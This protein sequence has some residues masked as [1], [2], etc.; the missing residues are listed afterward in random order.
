MSR[1]GGRWVL[2]GL[3]LVHLASLTAPFLAPYSPTGQNRRAPWSP[4]SRIRLVDAG[5]GLHWRPFVH[6]R[7]RLADGSWGE[8]TSRRLPLRIFVRGEPYRLFG[9]LEAD[10]HLFGVDAPDRVFLLGTDGLGRD[11]LSRL[12]FGARV[13][14]FA[15][16]AAAALALSLG[17]A[18]GALAGYFRGWADILVMRL[19]EVVLSLPA[20]YLLLGVRAFLPLEL[21]ATDSFL[22]IVA[23]IGLLGWP[24]PARLVRGV[25]LSGRERGY[26]T[27][28]RGFGASDLYLLRRHVLPQTVDVVLTQAAI[29]VPAYILAEVTLSFLGLGVSE[30]AASLGNMLAVLQRP[31]VLASY[32]WM[33][34]PAALLVVVILAYYALGEALKAESGNR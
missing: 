6:P 31:Q 23:I 27:A 3:V 29:L 25:V 30:P 10:R 2:A 19:V 18:L 11:Q 26:V 33:L 15:G 20:L 12:L 17:T 5:G 34:A 1:H 28:A 9:T 14:L 7:Q 24:K 22:V 8:D 16:L 13:S 32:D 21:S 4:P